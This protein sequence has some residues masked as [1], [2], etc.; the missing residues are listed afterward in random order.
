MRIADLFGSGEPV[1]S[2]E[3]FPPKTDRGFASLFRTIAELKRLDPAFV[4]VTWGAGGSTRRKTVE[5]VTRIQREIGICAMAHLSC[6]GSSRQDISDTLDG[7]V[8]TLRG[9]DGPLLGPC[10]Q[11][12]FGD[13]HWGIALRATQRSCSGGTVSCFIRPVLGESTGISRG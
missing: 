12:R 9:R 10:G 8:R 3:F 11:L 4:S 1:F 13:R 2:F 6:V 7:L 5:L